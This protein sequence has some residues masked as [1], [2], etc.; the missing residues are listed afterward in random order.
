MAVTKAAISGIV[1]PLLNVYFPRCPFPHDRAKGRR[2]IGGRHRDAGNLIFDDS[3]VHALP[4]ILNLVPT[5][6]RLRIRVLQCATATQCAPPGSLN[7][8]EA[9]DH[10]KLMANFVQGGNGSSC[11]SPVRRGRC[12]GVDN[13]GDGVG[14]GPGSDFPIIVHLTQ[15]S[16]DYTGDTAVED[17]R[18]TPTV[19]VSRR[20][21]HVPHQSAP[22]VKCYVN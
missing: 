22:P 4:L 3:H 8:H 19:E 20:R 5:D 10:L 9:G 21:K 14:G 6:Q 13:L 17:A 15:M 2:P 1:F 11:A 18:K 12:C 16:G 7:S